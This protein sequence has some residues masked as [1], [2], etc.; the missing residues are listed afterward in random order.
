MSRES[1]NLNLATVESLYV[2][3]WAWPRRGPFSMSTD[4]AGQEPDMGWI[5][6]L[7]RAQGRP[8]DI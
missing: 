5:F 4:G 8:M 1:S 2:R 6:A 7:P 3:G